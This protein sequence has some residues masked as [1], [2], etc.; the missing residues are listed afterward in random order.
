MTNRLASGLLALLLISTDAPAQVSSDRS[1]DRAYWT[2][3][4]P[5]QAASR[6]RKALRPWK[7]LPVAKPPACVS[8]LTSVSGFWVGSADPAM[9][10]I[11]IT[12][13]RTGQYTI[14]FQADGHEGGWRMRRTATFNS[15]ILEFS[16]PLLDY[17]L[18]PYCR[19]YAVAVGSEP[20]LVPET[21]LGEVSGVLAK[22]GC[23]SLAPE[24]VNGILY[25]PAKGDN[26]A[27]CREL[28]GL[29][30]GKK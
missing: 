6:V 4:S 18:P 23:R 14:L 8:P 22:R 25:E 24:W 2:N 9:G 13:H 27:W 20:W 12:M 3:A 16:G 15:G 29:P 5:S 17:E 7:P 10:C 11:R 1:F 19:M 28:L 30:T 21:T 26:E